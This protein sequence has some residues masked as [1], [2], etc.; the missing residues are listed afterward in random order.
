MKKLIIIPTYNE[1]KSLPILVDAVIEQN[2]DDC[3][4]LVVD[5]NSPDGTAETI[6]SLYPLDQAAIQVFVLNRA[7]K[8]GIG[9]AYIAGFQWALERNYDLIMQMDADYSHDPIYL[10]PMLEA[11][12]QDADVILGSR[13]V[14]GGGTKN[15]G[16]LRKIISRGGSWYAR[17]I[18]GLSIK[19]LTGGFKCFKREVL[20]AVDL[21]TIKTTGYAFQIEMTYRA[22]KKGF[23]VIEMPIIFCD[24]TV[25]QSK[26]SKAI[27]L[28]AVAKVFL[29]RFQK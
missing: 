20:Q 10:K 23:K 24:R 12:N 28:E 1:A 4:I 3:D 29:M 17:T 5:D 15:W 8:E 16:A 6:Q 27:I 21:N 2:I 22:I 25:G 11:I 18:L 26:M 9:R 13:Y 19:D 14:A 7:K